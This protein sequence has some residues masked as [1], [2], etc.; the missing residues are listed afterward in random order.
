[1]TM[2]FIR[3]PYMNIAILLCLVLL[4]AQ[5]ASAQSAQTTSTK[6]EGTAWS[7][8]VSDDG[9]DKG[10]KAVCADNDIDNDNDGLIELCYLE[11]VN[12]MRNN[13]RGTSLIRDSKTFSDGCGGGEDGD[14]CF[15]YELVRDLDFSNDDS[16]ESTS[17]NNVK[18]NWTMGEGWQPIGTIFNNFNSIFEGNGHTISSLRIKRPDANYVGLFGRT[19][20]GSKISNIGL[21]NVSIRGIGDT[22]GLVGDSRGSIANS[23]TSGSVHG[24]F[25]TGGLVGDS[26][27]NSITNSYASGSARGKFYIGGLV[28]QN[29]GNSIANSYATGFVKGRSFIG[30]LVGWNNNNIANS[31]ASGSVGGSSSVGGLVGFRNG[32][33]S[34]SYWNKDT[35]MGLSDSDRTGKTTAQLRSPTTATGIYSKWSTDNWD[36]DTTREYPALKYAQACGDSQQPVCGTLLRGQRNNQPRII[37]PTSKTEILITPNDAGTTKTISVTVSDNDIGDKVTVLLSAEDEEQNLVEFGTTKAEVLPNGNTDRGI[38]ED[39]SIRVP[40]VLTSGM[41][42]LRLVAE[43][44]SGFGNAMS[45]PVLF[46]VRVIANTP[47]TITPIP[48]IVLLDGTNTTLNVVIQDADGDALSVRLDSSDSTVATATIVATSGVNRTLKITG[49]STGTAV[50]TVTASDNEGGSAEEMFT[51]LVDAEPTGTVTISFEDINDDE[52]QLRAISSVMDANDIAETNYQWFKDNAPI[53]GA[54]TNTYTIPNDNDGRAGGTEYKV[55]VTFVDNI[56]QVTTLSDVYTVVNEAPVIMSVMP[57]KPNYEEGERVLVT[58]DASDANHDSLIYTW[59]VT[60]GAADLNEFDEVSEGATLSFKVPADWI[61][62]PSTATGV[63]ETLQLEIA[64]TEMRDG[65]ETTTQTAEVVVAKVNNGVS[66]TSSPK[67]ERTENDMGQTVLVLE[68]GTDTQAIAD[69]PDGNTTSPIK[70]QWQWCRSPCSPSSWAAI[71]GATANTYTIPESISGTPVM[72]NDRFRIGLSYTD[73]Q[74]YS[75]TIF[76]DTQATSASADLRVRTKVFLEG[77]LE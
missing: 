2:I 55:D 64:V 10:A 58:T 62:N 6:F 33:V 30:G 20:N 71:S 37:S 4:L 40:Q 1:M 16:Y 39:L 32:A 12:A 75:E 57:A 63:T 73:G 23:Y 38:N 52:W 45:E 72:D 34:R 42:T 76:S 21:L 14:E 59:S 49:S 46:K 3:K 54:T 25:R 9:E 28:G 68:T 19:N 7:D 35:S 31:Y 47:P 44:D 13:N 8:F 36:F 66:A 51:I 11:D 18:V 69:D 26:R 67:I 74:G 27:G 70:Y 5:A 17:T 53:L 50:I 60:Q 61:D 29:N 56:G 65:G 41:T 77:P 43:D 24:K 48:N 15:G 22:G